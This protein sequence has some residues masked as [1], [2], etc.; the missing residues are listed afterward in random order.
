MH[1]HIFV[2]DLDEAAESFPTHDAQRQLVAQLGVNETKRTLLHLLTMCVC[3]YVDL[4]ARIGGAR[5][6]IFGGLNN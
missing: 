4:V 5:I 1:L 2:Q 3:L 6:C